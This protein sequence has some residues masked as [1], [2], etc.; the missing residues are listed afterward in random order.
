MKRFRFSADFT[1][2]AATPEVLLSMISGHLASCARHLGSEREIDHV[3]R[4]FKIEELN[5]DW[6]AEAAAR[7]A[8]PTFDDGT[9]DLHDHVLEEHGVIDLDLDPA[10]P[11]SKARAEQ[12]E[13]E[14][15]EREAKN[16]ALANVGK[17]DAE[18]MAEHSAK[19][20]ARLN[21]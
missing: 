20:Q 3:C 10:S 12:V 19:E 6:D 11:A 5:V 13:R 15:S 1:F 8:D 14:K 2:N 16:K 17:T 7:K 4:H 21:G 9:T 18:I